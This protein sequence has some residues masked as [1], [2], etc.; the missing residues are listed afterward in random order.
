MSL[1][2]LA[3]LHLL[4]QPKGKLLTIR[5]IGNWFDITPYCI[6]FYCIDR[7]ANAAQ[8]T[9]TFFRSIMLPRI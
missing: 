9:A 6:A 8:W 5:P 7:V 1:A 2:K 3:Y 4:D